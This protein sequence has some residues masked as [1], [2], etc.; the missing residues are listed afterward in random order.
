MPAVVAGQGRVARQS[1]SRVRQLVD[2]R[3]RD[4]ELL[5]A[6]RH[7]PQPVEEVPAAV[8]TWDATARTDRQEDVAPARGQLLGQLGASLAGPDDQ[9]G[10]WW[11]IGRPSVRMRVEAQDARRQR[12]GDGR[13]TRLVEAAGGDDDLA[14]RDAAQA[15]PQLEAAARSDA[16]LLDIRIQHDRR[17]DGRCVARHAAHDLV[18]WHVAIRVGAVVGDPRE[19]RRPVGPDQTEVV[20]PILPATTERRATVE[21]HVVAAGPLEVPAHRQAGLAGAHD[22]GVDGGWQRGHDRILGSRGKAAQGAAWMGQ[23]QL[24][25]ASRARSPASCLALE[26]DGRGHDARAA[27]VLERVRWQAIAPRVARRIGRGVATMDLEEDLP[28]CAASD[29]SIAADHDGQVRRGMRVERRGL[30]RRDDGRDDPE[31]IVLEDDSMVVGCSDRAIEGRGLRVV[32][33]HR[34]SLRVGASCR[35]AGRVRMDATGRPAAS[36][37]AGP[38][39]RQE[40]PRDR[41]HMARGDPRGRMPTPTPSTSVGRASRATPPRRATSVPTS[42]TASRA[43]ARRS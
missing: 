39:T 24:I 29:V 38:M 27:D 25:A 37:I 36:T 11:Q 23:A 15:G 12:G 6:L 34:R 14:R 17:T 2:G 7:Q 13:Y 41:T 22:H 30:A 40:V 9:R 8:P 16:E 19:R 32:G 26:L 5:P 10:A 43:I 21:Q 20:P 35:A 33:G 31:V 18:A 1:P 3:Q 42:S 4:A 28:C